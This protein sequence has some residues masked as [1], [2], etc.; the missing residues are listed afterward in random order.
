[1]TICFFG[2][3]NPEYIRNDVIIQGLIKNKINLLICHTKYKGSLRFFDLIKM[4]FSYGRNCDFVFVGSSDTSRPLV[5]LAKIISR[6][7]IIWD[8]HYSI[9]DT[10][11]E[12]R[13]LAKPNSLKAYYYWFSD[14]LGCA[15]ADKVLLDTN[16][17]IDYFVKKFR[18]RKD[19]FIRI[20]VG[21]NEELLKSYLSK[22]SN[23]V[24]LDNNHFLVSFHGKYIPLQ[25][26]EY[27]IQAAKILEKYPDIKFKLI[28]K[29]QTYQKVRDL[30]KKINT[31]NINFIDRVPYKDIP[32]L[33]SSAHISLGIFGNSDKAL[34]VIPNKIYEAMALAK[35]IITGDTPGIKELFEDRKNIVLCRPADEKDLAEKILVLYKDRKLLNFIGEGAYKIFKDKC[36]PEIVVKPLL[37]KLNNYYEK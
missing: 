18:A 32:K 31:V 20:L 4:Y 27:I 35:P 28:G 33:I 7:P 25:G 37:E 11:V 1:M 3:Y 30:S 10:L 17:H 36:L 9:Y 21:A 26:V 6:K 14:W 5:V 16:H 34:R 12:D 23:S 29:G 24:G 13:K 8:A 2:D 15:V 19:K 22:E